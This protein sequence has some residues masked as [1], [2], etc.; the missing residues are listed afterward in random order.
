MIYLKEIM[1]LFIL[2][3]KNFIYEKLVDVCF[4]IVYNL[5]FVLLDR[6]IVLKVIYYG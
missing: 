1:I 3:W 4:S 6:L 2:I 5:I